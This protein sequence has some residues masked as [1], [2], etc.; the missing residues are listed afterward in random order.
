MELYKQACGAASSAGLVVCTCRLSVGVVHAHKRDHLDVHTAGWHHPC[1][2][3]LRAPGV[4]YTGMARHDAS[5]GGY[6]RFKESVSTLIEKVAFAGNIKHTGREV[7][8][9][10]FARCV[11]EQPLLLRP[12]VC[13]GH[14]EP[15][16]LLRCPVHQQVRCSRLRERTR[17]SSG[18]RRECGHG[19]L[20]CKGCCGDDLCHIAL[21]GP[22]LHLQA[23]PDRGTGLRKRCKGLL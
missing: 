7:H 5:V 15:V 19:T 12:L 18:S 2:Q 6:C 10:G 21:Q 20:H 11:G 14:V 8:R 4:R 13:L 16:L 3:P 23:H 22:C 17:D 1:R 9:C